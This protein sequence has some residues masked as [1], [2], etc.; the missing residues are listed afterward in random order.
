MDL[1]KGP[2]LVFADD[3]LRGY[4]ALARLQ[5]VRGEYGKACSTLDAFMRLVEERGFA[6]WLKIAG[7]MARVQIELAQDHLAAALHHVQIINPETIELP[8]LREHA[9]LTLARIHIAQSRQNPTVAPLQETLSLLDRLLQDAI[10]N[11]RMGSALEIFILQ[12]LALQTINDL[13]NALA[14]LEQAIVLAQ[15]QGYIRLFID[16]GKPMLILLRKALA[17]SEAPDYISTLLVTFDPHFDA[18][19]IAESTLIEP[20]TQR[21]RAVLALLLEGATNREIAAQLIVSVNTVKKH[22]FNI[23]GKL[24]VQS[25]IQAMVKA[26][27]LHLV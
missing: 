17:H 16:E 5:Q 20:L 26:R 7:T 25:R 15:S 18:P 19:S 14:T 23:C 21:E 4:K 1:L 22:I 24:G 11:G 2:L 27:E 9:Y 8:F 3:M 13:P 12:A 10:R 6:P